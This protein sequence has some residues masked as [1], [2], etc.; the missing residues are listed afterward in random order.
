MEFYL[1]IEQFLLDISKAKCQ[2]FF[3][4]MYVLVFKLQMI[5]PTLSL[6]MTLLLMRKKM[7]LVKM[8]CCPLVT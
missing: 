5:S 3:S 4:K 2:V 8:G 1:I 7:K 6:R